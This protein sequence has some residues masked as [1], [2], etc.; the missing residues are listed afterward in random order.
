MKKTAKSLLI[1]MIMAMVLATLTGCGDKKSDKEKKSDSN[2]LVA[3]K[4]LND[5]T[6]GTYKETVE[7]SF[8]NDKAKKVTITMDFEEEKDAESAE[9]MLKYVA[10]V[11]ENISFERNGKAIVA[12]MG[13]EEFI[14]QENLDDEDLSKDSLR[15][16]LE[17]DGYTIVE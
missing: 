3:T 6:L 12:T 4:T 15:K 16:E 13:T 9:A 2:T 5:S 8:E 11:S 14:G 17:D 10:Q 1:V 7:I